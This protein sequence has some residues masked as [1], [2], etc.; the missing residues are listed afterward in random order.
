M[1]FQTFIA[2][3]LTTG[4][5]SNFAGGPLTARPSANGTSASTH[6][7]FQPLKNSSP[8]K[9]QNEKWPI[10]PIDRFILAK[11]EQ[12]GLSPTPSASRRTLIRR[13]Y[14]DLVGLPPK[15]E[16]VEAFIADP[17]PRAYEKLVDRLLGSPAYGER[18]GRH[19]LDLAR[20]ADSDGSESDSDRPTAYHYRDFVI[21]ALNEDL[22]FNTF[23]RW[24]I[25]G[26][27]IEPDNPMAVSA[28]GFVVAGVNVP[29]PPELLE[30]ERIRERYNELDD[31]LSTTGVAFLGMTMG[32]ARCHDHKYDPIPTRD[33]Y[34]MATAFTSTE[35]KQAPLIPASDVAKHKDAQDR[36]KAEWDAA[37]K[38]GDTARVQ[39]LESSRPAPIPTVYS[40]RDKGPNPAESWL[41]E[42]GDF[43]RKKELVQVGFLTAL[44]HGKQPADYWSAAKAAGTRT[45]TTYQRR[46][47]A[48]WITDTKNGPGG[49]LARVAVNRLWQ[50]HF[51]EGIVR[52]VND[53][54][55]RSEPPTHPVLLEWLASE[56]VRGGWKLKPIHR[57]IL[58]SAT[59]RQGTA[60]SATAAKTDPENRLLWRRRPRRIESEI[61]RDSLLAA[62]GTL[63]PQMYGPGFKAPIL[64]EGIQA[65]NVKDAYPGNIQDAPENRRRSVYMFHKRVVPSPLLQVFDGP[66]A[67]TSCGRRNVTT[68]APQALAVLNEPFI[69]LR[70]GE[71]ARRLQSEVGKDAAA[72]VERAYR[73]A[74]S[75]APSAKELAA[76]NRFIER[77]K[78]ARAVRKGEDAEL[79]ALTDFAQVIF[80]LN[81]FVYVD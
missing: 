69:R 53:F 60:Y 49:L 30:E 10:T 21:K 41:L 22:P 14:F 18:W 12:K 54:G 38:A 52:T 61:Y 70:A 27:E 13:L 28:T 65:R 66:D 48:E 4:L 47:M 34:R 67:A 68:V 6:W 1:R 80:G 43:H 72:Q 58:L 17:D 73:L 33:Y 74:L 32:C 2:A 42:R 50:G 81:E 25:A 7:S 23:V 31:I 59:Y 11:L 36:W 39:S 79:H 78:T 15:P 29:L 16:E 75:R 26:D 8:P 63:N 71:F 24:Q 45:D 77:Q 44:T 64:P 62:A 55:K 37:K 51:G 19:W 3:T 56:L 40:L 35:R 5:L 20:Y 57:Q 9:V 46:A 76:A